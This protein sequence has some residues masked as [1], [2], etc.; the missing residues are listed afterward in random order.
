LI[1]TQANSWWYLVVKVHLPRGILYLPFNLLL[2]PVKVL[3]LIWISALASFDWPIS[4]SCLI[5][6][7]VTAYFGKTWVIWIFW[8]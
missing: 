5:S 8:V 1:I 2:G 7:G 3:P 6:M 4:D